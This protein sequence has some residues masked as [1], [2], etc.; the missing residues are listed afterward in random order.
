MRS[1]LQLSENDVVKSIVT[2]LRRQLQ[3]SDNE[4]QSLKRQLND[5]QQDNDQLMARAEQAEDSS[6]Q[7]VASVT[8][9]FQGYS[10]A[11]DNYQTEV[12]DAVQS[13]NE[14]R[15]KLDRDYRNRLSNLQG[16][17]DLANQDNSVFRAQIEELRKKTE[18]YRIR[19]QSPA[20]L[21]DGRVISVPV[22]MASSSS[23]LAR[24]TGSCQG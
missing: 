1:S 11:T 5:L 13:I 18:N 21:V 10:Q 15:Q 6:S 19:P 22:P 7:Q 3:S 20:E 8:Q 24:T 4:I 12:K 14:S 16:R 17:L 2:D 9:T 23:T